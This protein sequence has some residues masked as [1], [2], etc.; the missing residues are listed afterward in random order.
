MPNWCYNSGSIKCTEKSNRAV[1]DKLAAH[2][3][4]EAGWFSSVLPCPPE[5][6]LGID[7]AEGRAEQMNLEWLKKNSE[8]RGDFGS[9]TQFKGGNVSF[10]PTQE[11]KDYLT[12][13][14]GATNW[15][16]WRLKRYGCKWDVKLEEIEVQGDELFVSFSSAWGPP[17]EFFR[18]LGSQGLDVSLSYQESGQG[19]AGELDITDGKEDSEHH[20]GD[21]YVL[22]RLSEGEDLCDIYYDIEDFESYEEWLERNDAPTNKKL[23]AAIEAY[24]DEL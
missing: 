15:W 9:F 8:F 10:N 18:Y 23:V 21:D 14:Y 7:A 1:F 16:H 5:M 12:E 11:F 4:E 17:L 13:K 19:F 3:V 20:E 22:F 2:K 6:H 24:F